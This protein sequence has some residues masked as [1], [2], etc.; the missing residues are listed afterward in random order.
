MSDWEN[1]NQSLIRIEDKQDAMAAD[2]TEI[3]IDVAVHAVRVN[4]LQK[5]VF[6]AV[7]LILIVVVGAGLTKIVSPSQAGET[8]LE[9]K[10]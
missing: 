8:H 3:K 7:G 4:L 2:V 1:I 5:V 10:M 9:E 6:G